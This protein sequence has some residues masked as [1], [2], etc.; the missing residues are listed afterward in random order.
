MASVKIP[1]IAVIILTLLAIALTT[2]TF[3]TLNV[4]QNMSSMGTI[5]TT[6]NIGVYSNAACTTM[7]TGINWGSVSAGSSVCQ[8][9]YVK[10]TGTGSITLSLSTNNWAPAAVDGYITV[11]WNQA[12]TV[13]KAGQ[14][15]AATITLTA[16]PSINGITTFNNII[17]ISGTA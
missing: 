1:K 2:S 15:V 12:G 10:N 9:F 3:A 11:T 13:L 7:I 16:S 8:T 5:V 6:P 17:S 4:T 14:S